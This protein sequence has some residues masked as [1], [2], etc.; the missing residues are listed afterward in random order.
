VRVEATGAADGIRFDTVQLGGNWSKNV[1]Q[2]L[3]AEH[4]DGVGIRLGNID[5]MIIDLITCARAVGGTGYGLVLGAGDGV[6]TNNCRGNQLGM[7]APGDG[8]LYVEGTEIDT[9]PSIDNTV[10]FLD[11]EN[12]SADPVLGTDAELTWGT[13]R[14]VIKTLGLVKVGIGGSHTSAVTA[15]EEALAAEFPLVISSGNGKHME[16]SNGTGGKWSINISASTDGININ[17]VGGSGGLNLDTAYLGDY[18]ND[19][20]AA[21]GGVAV[22][23]MYRNGSVLMIRVA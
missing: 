23:Q 18:A 21:A 2:Y 19:G 1:A 20:A 10:W 4:D 13:S 3:Y 17:R 9:V 22:G 14:G 6:N 5:N 16:L 11:L 8:G 15:R 7:V 12:A